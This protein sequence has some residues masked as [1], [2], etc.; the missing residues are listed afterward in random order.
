MIW[1]MFMSSTRENLT[2]KQSVSNQL[3]KFSMGTIF[4]GR[5]W[6]NQ[7]S[8]AC[9]GLRIL[10]FCVTPHQILLG[11]NSWDGSKIHHNTELW[12]QSTENWWDSI[13][14]F[15]RIH[16]TAACLRSPKVHEQNGRTR[17]LPRTNYLHVDVQWHQSYGE[18]KTMKRNVLLIPHLCL[19]SKKDFQQNVGHSSDLGQK[20]SGTPLTKKDQEENGTESL[21]WWWSNSE[22]ADTHAHKYRRRKIIDTLLCRWRN[23]WNCF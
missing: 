19:Y 3:V 18:I 9:K 22:K 23:D 2:V 7:Q 11:S 13:G 8:L 16:Y 14:I 20:Q 1:R 15:H 17:T 21:N 5:W 10:R 4:S 12:T 6:R